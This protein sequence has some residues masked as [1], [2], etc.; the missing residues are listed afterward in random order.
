MKLLK[1]KKKEATTIIKNNL[2]HPDILKREIFAPL[3]SQ[4]FFIENM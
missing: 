2:E 1:R 3:C 4:T